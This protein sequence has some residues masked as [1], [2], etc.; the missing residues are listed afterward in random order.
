[1]P[2]TQLW[3]GQEGTGV[4]GPGPLME[5]TVLAGLP[6][7]ACVWVCVWTVTGGVFVVSAMAA[8]GF[9]ETMREQ[10]ACPRDTCP[11]V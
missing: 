2:S 1:M 5:P 3:A 8:L 4:T 11:R 10:V 7:P 6:L 9:V